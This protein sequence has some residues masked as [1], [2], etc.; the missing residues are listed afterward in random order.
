MV[1]FFICRGKLSINL[2][3]NKLI[4]AS[5]ICN[6]LDIWDLSLER[7]EEEE[8]EFK[9]QM[10]EQVNAPTDLPPTTSL[11]PSDSYL[12]A[13]KKKKNRNPPSCIDLLVQDYK[14]VLMNLRR[15]QVELRDQV[16]DLTL[17]SI[18]KDLRLESETDHLPLQ[19]NSKK[20]GE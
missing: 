9:A 10:K 15:S 16:V 14:L 18:D 19:A 17:P 12:T 5:S 1:I 4:Y 8:A 11:R 13:Q 6:Y 3:N 20:R 7:D 2:N